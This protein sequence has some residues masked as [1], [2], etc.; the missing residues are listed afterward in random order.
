MRNKPSFSPLNPV[1][2]EHGVS[3]DADALGERLTAA[4]ARADLTEDAAAAEAPRDDSDLFDAM[5][6]ED[7]REDIDLDP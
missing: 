1:V 5:L 4:L 3:V 6:A 7:L 2:N